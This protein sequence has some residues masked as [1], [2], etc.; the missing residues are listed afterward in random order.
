MPMCLGSSLDC[1]DST[2]LFDNNPLRV[3]LSARRAGFVASFVLLTSVCFVCVLFEDLDSK[4]SLD[5]P[6]TSML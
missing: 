3:P 2:G 5:N 4:P 1:N 6:R